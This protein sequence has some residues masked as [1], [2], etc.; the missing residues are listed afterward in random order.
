LILKAVKIIS[1]IE[2]AN[3]TFDYQPVK[4]MQDTINLVVVLLLKTFHSFFYKEKKYFC[5]QPRAA[6]GILQVKLNE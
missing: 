1:V 4:A 2:K 6:L 3:V 5:L